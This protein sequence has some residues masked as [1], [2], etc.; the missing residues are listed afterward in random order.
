MSSLRRRA[1]ARRREF[2]VAALCQ[3]DVLVDD[4]AQILRLWQRRDDLLVFDQGCGHVREH[5]LTMGAIAAEPPARFFMAHWS[6]LFRLGYLT[7]RFFGLTSFCC[8]VRTA[9]LPARRPIRKSQYWSSKR[10]ASSSMLSGGQFGTSI[11]RWRPIVARTSLISLSDLRP[12]FGVRSIS[13]S[14]F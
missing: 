14:L 1:A 8:P 13:A 3:R 12:K 5:G 9:H 10:L 11:P 4:T 6:S 7:G 2:K